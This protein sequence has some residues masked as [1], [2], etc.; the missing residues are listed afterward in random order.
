MLEIRDRIGHKRVGN[1]DDAGPEVDAAVEQSVTRAKMAVYI[2]K[3]RQWLV[4]QEKAKADEARANHPARSAGK[5]KPDEA[6]GHELRTGIDNNDVRWIWCRKC[7]AHTSVNIKALAVE[8]IGNKNSAQK[9]R[10]ESECNPYT[11][12]RAAM[13]PADMQWCDVSAVAVLQACQALGQD[14]SVAP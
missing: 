7:G 6:K 4:N 1:T 9:R 2:D 5:I 12:K 10:L 13:V 3:E 14:D 11:A 8:C